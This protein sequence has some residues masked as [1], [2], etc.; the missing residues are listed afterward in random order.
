MRSV[1]LGGVLL[2]IGSVGASAQPWYGPGYYGS[3]AP[4]RYGHPGPGYGPAYGPGFYGRPPAPAYYAP[5]RPRCWIRPG[6]W[7]PERVC[8]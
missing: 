2:A 5:P 7:G 6:Y 4:P 8:R 1:I 3:P